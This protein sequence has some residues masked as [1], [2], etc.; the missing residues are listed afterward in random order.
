MAIGTGTGFPMKLAAPPSF[1]TM[2]GKPINAS[3]VGMDHFQTKVFALDL[4]RHLPPFL[5]VHLVP[6]ALR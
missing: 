2:V 6:M 5:A 4:P 3:G 1:E